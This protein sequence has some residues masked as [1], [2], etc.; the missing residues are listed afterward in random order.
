M[1]GDQR[2]HQRH[3]ISRIAKWQSESAGLPRDCTITNLSGGGARLFVDDADLPNR[4]F[5]SI[6][7]DVP[8]RQECRVVWR[9][10]GEVGVEFVGKSADASRGESPGAP[11]K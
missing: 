3:S 2:K 4:F 11:Q 8:M 7:G 9:L 10:G 1:F 5:L 6:S